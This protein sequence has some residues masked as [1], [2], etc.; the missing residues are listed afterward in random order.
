M[1]SLRLKEILAEEHKTKYWFIKHME[2]G[3]QALSRLLNNETKSIHYDTLN[4]IC[5]ILNRTPGDIFLLDKKND[6]IEI[7]KILNKILEI[8]F[9][10]ISDKE[11]LDLLIK[12]QFE[13]SSIMKI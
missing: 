1:I 3:Y 8:D 10:S 9:E 5:N 7:K 4:K 2:G 6:Y 12:L 13:L 11:R